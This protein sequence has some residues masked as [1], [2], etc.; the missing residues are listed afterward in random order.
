MVSRKVMIVAGESSGELYGALLAGKL[1]TLWPDIRLM[2]IGGERMRK[3]GVELFAEIASSFGI[4]EAVSTLRKVKDTFR[5]TVEAVKSER[6]DVVVLIDYPDFNFRVGREARKEG[7]RVLYYVSPQVWA[8]RSGRVK[9]IAEV[10][11]RIAVILPFEE[12]IYKDAGLPCEFVGHPVLDEINLLPNNHSELKKRLGLNADIKYIALLPGSRKHELKKLLP[13]LLKVVRKI[14]NDFPEYG[15]V[16]PLAPNLDVSMFSHVFDEFKSEGV[17]ILYESSVPALASSEAAVVASGTAA[18][19]SAFV[20]TPLV[21]IYKIFPITYFIGRT[22][23]LNVKYISLANILLDRP[24]VKELLQAEA[25]PEGITDEL[26]RIL[27]DVAYRESVL[28]GF[29]DVRSLY[30]GKRPSMRVAEMVGEMA[31]WES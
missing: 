25:N 27:H 4:T 22:F 5:M 3:A 13:V 31:G 21:V 23:I 20:G 16:M 30:E 10:A 2:G 14:K 9:A 18:L 11:N 6:P 12:S 24:V 17:V 29:D 28:A 15:F 1:K 19:Q 26:A 8:W 7:I